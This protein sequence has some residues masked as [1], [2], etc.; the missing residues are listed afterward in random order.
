M[1]IL[2]KDLLIITLILYS[3]EENFVSCGVA[4]YKM[5]LFSYCSEDLF[6]V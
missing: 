1:N 6:A 5:Q 4:I 2:I 3:L